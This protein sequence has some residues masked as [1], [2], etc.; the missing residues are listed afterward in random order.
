MGFIAMHL[1]KRVVG[2]SNR[3]RLSYYK[4]PDFR[5]KRLFDLYHSGWITTKVGC[6]FTIYRTDRIDD[7]C[8]VPTELRIPQLGV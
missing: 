7:L 8:S 6:V 2:V 3:G 1:G 4:L 5:K